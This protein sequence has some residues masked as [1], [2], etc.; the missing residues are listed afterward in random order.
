ML[1]SVVKFQL[2]LSNFKERM[3]DKTDKSR[4]LAFFLGLP[5][6]ILVSLG[7]SFLAILL[8]LTWAA[9]TGQQLDLKAGMLFL[10]IVSEISAFLLFLIPFVKRVAKSNNGLGLGIK[11]FKKRMHSASTGRAWG[12]AVG[13]GVGSGLALFGLAQVVANLVALIPHASSGSQN[14]LMNETTKMLSSAGTD[15]FTGKAAYPIL[16]A[17]VVLIT[18]LIGPF[19]EECLFRGLI[20]KSLFR[21]SVGSLTAPGDSG[22]SRSRVVLCSLA[23][24]LVFGVAHAQ[25]TGVFMPDLMSV[26]IPTL[27]GSVFSW[28]A[29]RKYDSLYP[30]IIGHV[31][32]NSVAMIVAIVIAL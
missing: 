8:Y 12:K 10:V 16:S 18:V 4:L 28:I 7:G 17:G 26:L 11:D 5:L 32:Y 27:I 2:W 19:L 6:F 9:V 30:T 21:S 13:V 3:Q 31:T 1:T 29:C 20:G 24:G 15:L 25:F 14:D 23:S 22:P